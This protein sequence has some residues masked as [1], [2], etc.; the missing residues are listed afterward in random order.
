MQPGVDE[1]HSSKHQ[2]IYL[3]AILWFLGLQYKNSVIAFE[4]RE[5]KASYLLLIKGGTKYECGD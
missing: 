3:I 5:R 4:L 1:F 2:V